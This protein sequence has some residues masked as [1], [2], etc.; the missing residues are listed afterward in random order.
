MVP[1]QDLGIELKLAK[2]IMPVRPNSVAWCLQ[3]LTSFSL[4]QVEQNK[5]HMQ[6]FADLLSRQ[7]KWVRRLRCLSL[8]AKSAEVQPHK[9][10]LDWT[11]AV[12]AG[13]HFLAVQVACGCMGALSRSPHRRAGQQASCHSLSLRLLVRCLLPA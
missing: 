4:W 6:K 5:E 12:R 13:H 11:G 8:I 9:V 10:S 1:L 7:N 2:G 3:F